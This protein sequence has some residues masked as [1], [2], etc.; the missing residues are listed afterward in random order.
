MVQHHY[1]IVGL[2]ILQQV[3]EA[4]DHLVSAAVALIGLAVMLVM[5]AQVVVVIQVNLAVV[6]EVALVALAE[7]DGV[8][9]YLDLAVVLLAEQ[10][11][12]VHRHGVLQALSMALG[13]ST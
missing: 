3:V 1:R 5:T 7:M 13:Y 10:Y 6:M 8:I 11:S 9:T 2:Q 12:E 4:V